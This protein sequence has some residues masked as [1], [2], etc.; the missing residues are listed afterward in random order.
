MAVPVNEKHDSIHCACE[1]WAGYPEGDIFSTATAGVVGSH[2]TVTE[3]GYSA[4]R[5]VITTQLDK[6]I[7][8]GY[9]S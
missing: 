7:L 4:I 9:C 1:Y 6:S 3:L 2:R 5:V 8:F